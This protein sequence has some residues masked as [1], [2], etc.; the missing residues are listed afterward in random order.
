MNVNSTSDLLKLQH[1]LNTTSNS[2]LDA[3]LRSSSPSNGQPDPPPDDEWSTRPSNTIF[4]L[5]DLL[6]KIDLM[7]NRDEHLG[8]LLG[9]ITLPLKPHCGNTNLSAYHWRTYNLFLV[10]IQYFIPLIVITF[11]YTKMGLKLRETDKRLNKRSSSKLQR[12]NTTSSGGGFSSSSV[13]TTNNNLIVSPGTANCNVQMAIELQ[14]TGGQPNPM[15][16]VNKRCRSL[17]CSPLEEGACLMAHDAR[18]CSQSTTPTGRYSPQC[19]NCAQQH[20]HVTQMNSTNVSIHSKHR[21]SCTECC[22]EAQMMNAAAHNAAIQN[23]AAHNVAAHNVAAHNAAI[24]NATGHNAVAHNTAIQN[25][26]ANNTTAQNATANN[27]A[28]HNTGNQNMVQNTTQNAA[29]VANNNNDCMLNKNVAGR[30]NSCNASMKKGS[31]KCNAC[32]CRR[33]EAA[34]GQQPGGQFDHH[35]SLHRHH[36]SSQQSP[37]QPP[38]LQHHSSLQPTGSIHSNLMMPMISHPITALRVNP[39]AEYIV[40]NKKKVGFIEWNFEIRMLPIN[41]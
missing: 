12:I 15:G 27:T 24:Q 40:I 10:L 26:S 33:Y 37:Q 3:L 34:D 38:P 9:N 17:D 28:V 20:T 2:N 1:T 25:A 32:K 31:C 30:S 5:D 14:Q 18:K 8:T 4:W 16:A 11:A 13:R 7:Q 19:F 29:I 36:Q 22:K 35:N 39:H 41:L 6:A 23:A 21:T